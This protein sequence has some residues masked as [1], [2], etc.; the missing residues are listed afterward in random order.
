MIASPL[1]ATSIVSRCHYRL[2][3]HVDVDLGDQAATLLRRGARPQRVGDPE[4]LA[5]LRRLLPPADAATA[6]PDEAGRRLLELGAAQFEWTVDALGASALLRA[7]VDG[8]RLREGPPPACHA[9][10][11]G[12]YVGRDG[13][14]LRVRNP[15]SPFELRLHGAGL[16][17]GRFERAAEAPDTPEKLWLQGLGELLWSAGLSDVPEAVDASDWDLADRLFHI[18][19]RGRSDGLPRGATYRRGAELPT[20][21][22]QAAVAPQRAHRRDDLD[23]LQAIRF[24]DVLRQRRSMR[25][26]AAP[27][28]RTD[29]ERLLRLSFADIL[30]ETTRSMPCK[31][32]AFASAG[33]MH[34][35]DVYF[36]AVDIDGLAPGLHRF[37]CETGTL[38][39]QSAPPDPLRTM[40][41]EARKAWGADHGVPRGLIVLCADL[42][43]MT[44]RYEAI[45]YRLSLLNAGHAS[46]ALCQIG[47][48]LGIGLCPLGSGDAAAFAEASGLPEWQL[49]AIAEIAIAGAVPPIG[50]A[51]GAPFLHPPR[52]TP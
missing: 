36:V 48:A 9:L 15:A 42:P 4:L 3:P 52:T 20:V 17:T 38:L 13:D 28:A 30:D 5:A 45:A 22:A 8:A 18:A 2:P 50:A 19:S 35:L 12:T 40:L 21:R 26:A 7:T 44:W 23:H 16:G 11:P 24:V 31:A 46:M 33:G 6:L 10:H 47:A 29:V 14:G 37:C 25:G 49:P 1:S 51:A 39:P 41:A 32:R 27:L 34:E 43:L